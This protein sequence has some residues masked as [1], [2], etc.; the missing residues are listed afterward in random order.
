[1]VAKRNKEMT[2][3]D[4]LSDVKCELL[5]KIVYIYRLVFFLLRQEVIALPFSGQ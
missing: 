2:G 3:W 5:Q 4:G 1:M